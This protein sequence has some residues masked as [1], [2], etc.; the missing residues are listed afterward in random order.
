[1]PRISPADAA[2]FF[3]LA[4]RGDVRVAGKRERRPDLDPP[5]RGDLASDALELL[6][7]QGLAPS[8]SMASEL[9]SFRLVVIEKR[10][11]A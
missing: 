6:E 5:L 3:D 2:W 4:R 1:M 10:G 9:G 7:A 8:I 11:R